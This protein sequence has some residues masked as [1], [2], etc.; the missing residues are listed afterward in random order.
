KEAEPLPDLAQARGAG[1]DVG[2]ELRGDPG[3]RSGTHVPEVEAGEDDEAVLVPARGDRGEL[4]FQ[5]VPRAAVS[6]HHDAKVE[7]IHGRADALD[8]L[9]RGEPRRMPV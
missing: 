3:A 8:D 1:G 4:L 7:G 9:R 6:A 2:L 5:P